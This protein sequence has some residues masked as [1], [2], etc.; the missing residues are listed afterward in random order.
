MKMWSRVF[1][2]TALDG[3][4]VS[5]ATLSLQ[6]WGRGPQFQLEWG[7]HLGIG[8]DAIERRTASYSR[9]ESNLELLVQL[10]ESHCIDILLT[11]LCEPKNKF[12]RTP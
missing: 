1:L 8:L 12:T 6:C 4:D 9:R 7:V 5:F 10:V 2:A 3:F 11:T